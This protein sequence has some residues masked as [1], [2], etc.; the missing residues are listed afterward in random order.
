MVRRDRHRD[1]QRLVVEGTDV[2]V[3]S[4]CGDTNDE[5]PT[6]VRPLAFFELTPIE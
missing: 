5:L 6:F 3:L 1:A 4:T 2:A